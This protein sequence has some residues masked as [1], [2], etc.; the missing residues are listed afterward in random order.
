MALYKHIFIQGNV[1]SERYRA[2][3]AM[4][5]KPRIPV[6]DRATQ[7]QKLLNQ[8]EAIWQQKEQLQQQRSAQQIATREG[9]YVQFTS[10][11]DHD[12]I[13]KS[14]E[15]LRKGI[16]LL[17]IKE[18]PVGENQTQVR[19][20]V[21]VPNGKE[22][23]FI[24]KINSYQSKNN[25]SIIFQNQLNHEIVAETINQLRYNIRL[26]SVKDVLVENV[27]RTKAN[28][29]LPVGKEGFLIDEILRL[30]P[31][32]EINITPSNSDLVN[33]IED[34]SLALLEGLWTDNPQLIPTDA[35]KWCEAWLNVNAKENQ[36]LE[37]IAQFHATLESIGIQYKHNS[38]IFP[39][40]AVLLIN[41]NRDQLVELMLQSDLLAEFRAGQE[42]AGF[43]VNESSIEQ[44]AWVDDLLNRVEL[45]ESNIKVCLLDS[46]VNNG[47]QLLQPLIDDA[48][49]LTADNTWGT[50]DHEKKAGHGTLM[51][52][53]AGYGQMEQVLTSANAVPLTHKLCSV[54]ILPRPNQAQTPRELWGDI[55]T[56]GI[57]RAEIQ[58]PNMV[59]IYCM[60]VTSLEDT[61]RGRP[62]SWSGAIDNLAFG[63][64]ENQRLIIISAGNIRDEELWQNYPNSNF[65]TSV[66]NPAQAWN[67][68]VAGAYTKKN[69]V[70]DPNFQNHTPIANEGELSPYSS[71]SL[72]WE[73]KWAV[74]PDVV[75]EGGNLLRAPDNK[76]TPHEDLELLSTSRSI[77][78]KPFDTIN[79]TSAAAA[80]AS[81]FAAKIAYEYP[82]AWAETIRGLMVHSAN[83]HP[84]ML[85]QIQVKQGNR[86]SFRNLLRAF[87]YGVPDLDRALYSK[88]SALTYI[89]QET[90][91]PFSFKDR[92]STPET[93]EIHFYNLPWAKDLLL[94]MGETPVKLKVTLSYFIE[95][96]AG[97]IGWKDKYRYQSH[98]LRFD[99]NN[100][101]E[102]K[103][104]FRRRV[105][106]AA[107]EENE[108]VNGN[109][110]SNRW[111][112][113]SNN[114]S[115]GSIHSDY[116]E[117]T[118]AALATCNHI[119]VY[120]VIG[121]WHQ[122]KHLGKVKN[123]TRYA[124]I[125][126]LETPAQDI[127]L[128]TTVKNMIEV[129][130]EIET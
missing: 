1:S 26:K 116:W 93:N 75:F 66:Q 37:Q 69:Q 128:Y 14:L 108:E 106:I 56:Q 103:D 10:A 53:I 34:V 105:N 110:G 22:G 86:G 100:V 60:S 92:S 38:I 73:R 125:V 98:G 95:P 36:E 39:E 52:G 58:N 79:A 57:A 97:E 11:A 9:T 59:L 129:P 4:G 85:A 51:A 71:T 17:N 63:E 15:D 3:S 101:N 27:T 48:N 20:T 23:L 35:T 107:R 113:G 123:R 21:Y 122:R 50:E 90:I 109:A 54:K 43:W 2:P 76:V 126:S 19:A 30:F 84:A 31:N 8:F 102:S 64:G 104:D 99:V 29:H 28:I 78:I 65:T 42:P 74:K 80:Q 82:D 33:S 119:A 77:Q 111:A 40:R 16:R 68:L 49:T 87:G 83:W 88:E 72:L 124:L 89:A 41:A 67:A 115:T 118:A 5:A 96:G 13:T 91:Q 55:T 24:D 18:I 7:S 62:S 117:G 94:Q 112:I 81:W 44:Q 45:V 32:T 61:D 6:R 25:T 120:P 127:E 12:L 130:I 114:R 46:G 70:N 121:W 47:H